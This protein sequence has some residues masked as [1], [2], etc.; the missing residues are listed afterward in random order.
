ML[1]NTFN[2]SKLILKHST[3]IVNGNLLVLVRFIS[4]TKRFLKTAFCGKLQV[5]A[6]LPAV[7]AIYHKLG[8]IRGILD[9]IRHFIPPNLNRFEAFKNYF[10]LF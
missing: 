2:T 8:Y 7:L 1:R 10:W 6:Q 4:I 3:I 9:H 5:F